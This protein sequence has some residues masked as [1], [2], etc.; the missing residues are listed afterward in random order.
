MPRR[1]TYPF[2]PTW[3]DRRFKKSLK[4]LSPQQQK[5]CL[6][7]LDHLIRDLKICKHPK[8]DPILQRWKP[9]P[10]KRVIEVSDI[11]EYR[12]GRMMRV[13]ARFLD[14]APGGAVLLLAV[15]LQHDH[16]RIQRLMKT[17]KR[18]VSTWTDPED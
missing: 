3:L 11:Y 18:G 4:K 13:I 12:C 16:R 9:G 6:Q 2:K 8:A 17:H 10:Y 7:E 1:H 5:E 14:P 15:T